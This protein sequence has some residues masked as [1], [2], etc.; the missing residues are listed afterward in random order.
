VYVPENYD[1]NIAHA[2]VLWLHPARKLGKEAES[3]ADVWEEY[4]TRHH[5]IMVGPKAE[6]ENGWIPSESDFVLQAVNEVMGQYT[7]DRQRV[8]AHGMGVGG[9]M[10]FYLGFSAR[11]LIR[12]VATTGA[13]LTREPKENV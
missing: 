10:A 5:I 1:P 6:N 9:Q 12:G 11:D 3:I 13:V 2:L 4:C 7:I 8:V